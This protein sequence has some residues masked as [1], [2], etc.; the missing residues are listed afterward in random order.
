MT[1]S[2]FLH[3]YCASAILFAR[4]GA[5]IWSDIDFNTRVVDLNDIKK[6]NKKTKAIVIV[7]LYGFAVDLKPIQK[8]LRNKKILI[9]EDCAQ[10]WS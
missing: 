4:N 1:K 6:I 5:K 9:I 7:H 8:L 3:T 2:L 10:A